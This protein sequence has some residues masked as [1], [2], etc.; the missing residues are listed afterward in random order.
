[1]M[2]CSVVSLLTTDL[3]NTKIIDIIF[4]CKLIAHYRLFQIFRSEYEWIDY[5]KWTWGEPHFGPK[6]DKIEVTD[7]SYLTS[8][9]VANAVR[10]RM[11][12]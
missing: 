5:A 12:R 1:M 10:G 6:R 11:I 9:S 3:D 2:Y 8:L 4:F 7:F